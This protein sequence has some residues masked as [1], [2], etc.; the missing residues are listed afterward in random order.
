MQAVNH[1]VSDMADLCGCTYYCR[2][3]KIMSIDSLISRMGLEKLNKDCILHSMFRV[4]IDKKSKLLA[5]KDEAAGGLI[6][7]LKDYEDVLKRLL[8]YAK[9][10]PAS[11]KNCEG[12]T[13]CIDCIIKNNCVDASVVFYK[14]Q[15]QA[16]AV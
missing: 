6:N 1:H 3:E 11:C 9:C 16:V 15:Q 13:K 2:K 8:N 7:Q 10:F 12:L 5:C 14:L 4:Y